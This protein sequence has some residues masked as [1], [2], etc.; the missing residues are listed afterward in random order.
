MASPPTGR[1]L[2]A[3]L[4]ERL[5]WTEVREH[6]LPVGFLDKLCWVGCPP[7]CAAGSMMHV[8]RFSEDWRAAGELMEA[9]R[10]R[11][12]C[13]ALWMYEGKG[14]VDAV[15]TNESSTGEEWSVEGQAKTGPEA[16]T[17]AAYAALGGA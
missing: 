11:G 15:Y 6:K 8:P 17:L 2:D 16:I 13:L 12:F 14:T 5:G 3:W 9:M 1:A 10:E 7:S 4:A